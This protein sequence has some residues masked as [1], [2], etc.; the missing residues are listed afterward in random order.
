[1][2][3]N[4]DAP[5]PCKD[6]TGSPS[7]S[8]S[9]SSMTTEVEQPGKTSSL[10]SIATKVEGTRN[11]TWK[12]TVL[13]TLIPSRSDYKAARV[14]DDVWWKPDDYCLFQAKFEKD[15]HGLMKGKKMRLKGGLKGGT[16]G[17]R[18]ASIRQFI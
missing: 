7:K 5:R 8:N 2:G 12:P 4:V 11:V 16:S 18:N 10:K 1:M 15:F 6:E 17:C 13:V 9:L 3:E 14:F